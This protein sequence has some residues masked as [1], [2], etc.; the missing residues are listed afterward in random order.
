LGRGVGGLFAAC[1]LDLPL[2]GGRQLLVARPFRDLGLAGLAGLSFARGL[3]GTLAGQLALNGGR[4]AGV[5][6]RG[7]SRPLAGRGRALGRGSGHGS[8]RLAGGRMLYR[9]RGGRLGRRRK[10]VTGD[11]R[12]ETRAQFLDL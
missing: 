9:G 3:L 10:G 6:W 11:G 7:R 1:A 4:Q 5:G 2:D 8:R 12:D